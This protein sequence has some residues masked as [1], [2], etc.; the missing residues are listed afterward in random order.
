MITDTE[1]R[2]KGIRVLAQSL[3]D[4]E[5]ERF[6]S[7]IQREP[8][9]YTQWRQDRWGDLSIDEISRKAMMLREKSGEQTARADGEDNAN[10]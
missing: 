2:L 4:I 3:G 6:I 1:L 7:L 5:A 8:F 9:D 10:G